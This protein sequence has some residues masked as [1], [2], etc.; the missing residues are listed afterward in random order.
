[1]SHRLL[2]PCHA[3]ASVLGE[4]SFPSSLQRWENTVFVKPKL[5]E[6]VTILTEAMETNS[7]CPLLGLQLSKCSSRNAR[8][9]HEGSW[10][11]S[12]TA[13]LAATV[14]QIHSSLFCFNTYSILIVFLTGE[15]LSSCKD[16]DCQFS[17]RFL[18]SMCGL[19]IRVFLRTYILILV[20]KYTHTHT[21][22]EL[23]LT[24]V[25]R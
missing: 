8:L 22:S 9:P 18:Q 24:A 4:N 19:T 3:T 10:V 20:H 14:C 23:N 17:K 7:H 13:S 12:G 21:T 2:S 11:D 5:Q 6:A 25:R 1:M 15:T 16:L